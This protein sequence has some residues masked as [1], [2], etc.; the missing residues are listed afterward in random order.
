LFHFEADHEFL[1]STIFY[2]WFKDALVF[3]EFCHAIEYR[4][5]LAALRVPCPV[6]YALDGRKVDGALD[7]NHVVR[8]LQLEYSFGE[9][10][11]ERESLDKILTGKLIWLFDYYS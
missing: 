5:H 1:R 2:D 7:P 3:E 10:F 11:S 9:F 8:P 4:K 6:L